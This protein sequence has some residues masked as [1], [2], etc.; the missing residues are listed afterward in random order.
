[1]NNKP[2]QETSV[3]K[4]V[5][6]RSVHNSFKSPVIVRSNSSHSSG[7]TTSTCTPA[8]TGKSV[9]ASGQSSLTCGHVDT[10]Q[11]QREVED[12]QE[13]LEQVEQQIQQLKKEGLDES[14]LEEH[15]AKLHEYNEIKDTAQMILGHIATLQGVRTRDVYP[16]YGLELDD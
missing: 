6:R 11:L 16:K 8:S 12:L 15:I 13:Q 1:M 7:A 4:Q 14:E 2:S 3:T 5:T 9:E 10:T